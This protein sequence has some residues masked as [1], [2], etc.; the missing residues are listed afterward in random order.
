MSLTS[1]APLP[2]TSSSSFTK[3]TELV[4]DVE[5]KEYV[6]RKNVNEVNDLDGKNSSER[7]QLV[8]YHYQYLYLF[9]FGFLIILYMMRMMSSDTSI[10]DN[11]ILLIL[12]VLIIH[13]FFYKYF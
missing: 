4:N 5:K 3:F 8:S 11:I 13:H 2:P 7:L 6:I 1:S 12:A 10:I 9:I